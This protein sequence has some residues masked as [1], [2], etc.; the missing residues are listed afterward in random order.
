VPVVILHVDPLSLPSDPVASAETCVAI[1]GLPGSP[2]ALNSTASVL[3]RLGDDVAGAMSR[4]RAV[5]R[6]GSDWCGEAAD[7]FTEKVKEPA[8][9]HIDDVPARYRAYAEVLRRYA[10]ELDTAQADLAVAR[11]RVQAALDAY[12]SAHA[13][14]TGG[15]PALERRALDCRDAVA[16]F[17]NRYDTWVDAANR[18]VRG[19]KH[20]DNHDH[21]H[22]PHG[23]HA[24]VNALST[25]IGDLSTI[26]AVLGVLAL[27]IC[28]PAAPV[29]F[30]VSSV[31]ASVTLV[32]DLD[33]RFQ[34]DEDVSWATVGADALGAIP[35]T[36]VTRAGRGLVKGALHAA[37]TVS[38]SSAG[39]RAG[40]KGAGRVYRTTFVRAPRAGLQTLRDGGGL[41]RSV[42]EPTL[43]GVRASAKGNYQ[44]LAALPGAAAA[45]AAD[46]HNRKHESWTSAGLH[47]PFR[48]L[49][50][51][52]EDTVPAGPLRNTIE[53]LVPSLGLLDCLADT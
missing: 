5:S 4:L 31:A 41:S 11:T 39:V 36:S 29:L 8:K 37:P 13:S 51:P 24:F 19:L 1:G 43:Q 48:V 14:A 49:F 10:S 53:T 40:L 42:R 17:R 46:D 44:N 21:L 47:S 6:L 7:A 27:A 16:V 50:K 35:I 33:R 52:F 3:A 15:A 22:N 18:C 20:I 28:P 2:A 32:A 30:A 38:R 23:M 26:T 9:A 25:V 34:Y 45:R 12:R